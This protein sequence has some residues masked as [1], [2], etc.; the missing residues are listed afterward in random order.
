MPD[1]K[2]HAYS[3]STESLLI[4]NEITSEIFFF[5]VFT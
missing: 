2:A 5:L 4:V 3:S 1:Y